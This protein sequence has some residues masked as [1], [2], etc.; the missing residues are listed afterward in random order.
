MVA[1]ILIDV[2]R[3]SEAL[4]LGRTT[5][6][7]LIRSGQLRA[8]RVGRAVRFEVAELER[9]AAAQRKGGTGA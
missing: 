7:E 2:R 3:A 6:Y 5:L 8:V 1:P 4:S 9:F